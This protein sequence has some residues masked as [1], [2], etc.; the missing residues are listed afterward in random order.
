MFAKVN[1]NS[2]NYL[3]ITVNK[4][5]NINYPDS[6]IPITFNAT[7][8]GYWMTQASSQQAKKNSALIYK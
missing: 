5:K 1:E 8:V 6:D 2:S 4:I 7:V 3:N